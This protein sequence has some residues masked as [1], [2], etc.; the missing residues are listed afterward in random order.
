MALPG[1]QLL[2]DI[3]QGKTLLGNA[4]IP[5]TNI[6]AS[7][8]WYVAVGCIGSI[9]LA[10]TPVAPVVLGVMPLAALYQLTQLLAGH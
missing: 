6:Q 9:F 10:A 5:G 3:S 8:G 2:N 1:Q 4:K 7:T